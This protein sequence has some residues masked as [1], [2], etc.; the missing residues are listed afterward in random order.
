MESLFSSYFYTSS[1]YL[2]PVTSQPLCPASENRS[3]KSK[4]SKVESNKR[5]FPFPITS[6]PPELSASSRP[7]RTITAVKAYCST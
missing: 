5:N 7:D 2:T 6:H 3:R 4:R 1:G